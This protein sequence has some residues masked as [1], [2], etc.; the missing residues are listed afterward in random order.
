MLSKTKAT[1]EMTRKYDEEI[2]VLRRDD[3]F[4]EQ[5]A[6]HGLQAVDFEFYKNL[7]KTKQLFIPRGLAEQ[8]P[9]FKQIIPYLIFRHKGSY[10][11]MQ[12]SAT[13]S[14][15]RLANSYTLGIGGHLRKE[16]IEKSSLIEWAIREFHEEIN[17]EGSFTV[18]PLGILNDDSNNVGKVHVGIVLLL[19]GDSDKISIKS[20]LK[21]GFLVSLQ[22]CKKIYT[23][24]ES[25][26]QFVVDYLEKE[27]QNKL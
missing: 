3:F 26:T 8:D 27:A 11:L 5:P 1:S 15:Q 2:V 24:L 21:S 16:D 10:F 4:N 17:Y 14:E 6:W 13:S 20:E 22:E 23:A 9:T 7:I 12:R 19:E 25:W 18:K